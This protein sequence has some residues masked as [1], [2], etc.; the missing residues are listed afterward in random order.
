MTVSDIVA[1][2]PSL[3]ALVIGDICLDRWCTYYPSAA[4]P[5]RE[6]G[7]NRIA[8]TSTECT[9]GGGGTVANNLAAFGLARVAVLGLV[10]DDGHGFELK[11]AL[12]Q[13]GIATECLIHSRDICTFTYSKLINGDTGIEDLPRVDFIFSR[14]V[15]VSLLDSMCHSLLEIHSEF[16][17]ILIADQAEVQGEG[18]VTESVRD[19]LAR[20]GCEHPAKVLW[21]DSRLHCELFRHVNMKVNRREADAACRRAFGMVDYRRLQKLIGGRDLFVTDGPNQALIE[22]GCETIR[23][24]PRRI[25]HPINICGAGD[26]FSAGTACAMALGAKAKDA[27]EFGSLVASITVM[28]PGTGT[29]SRQELLEQ[30]DLVAIGGQ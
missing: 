1:G 2:L 28:K 21:A 25:D 12:E 29:A 9:P 23:V 15:P 17:L 19:T 22:T 10:G 30:A 16:D 5:S 4:S 18:A 26:S 11:R 14:P 13:N 6:T 20:I 7:L 3:R 24:S 27:A 8:V